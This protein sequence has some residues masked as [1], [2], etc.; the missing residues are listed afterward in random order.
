MYRPS[1]FTCTGEVKQINEPLM[2]QAQPKCLPAQGEAIEHELMTTKSPSELH[3]KALASQYPSMSF[4]K[5]IV[6]P[7]WAVFPVIFTL[8]CLKGLQYP[9]LVD[10][11][12][13]MCSSTSF[14]FT[15]SP[16]W[17]VTNLRST[18]HCVKHKC[19][20]MPISIGTPYGLEEH[21]EHLEKTVH[22][23]Q[24]HCSYS[25]DWQNSS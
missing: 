5:P 22:E 11:L 20:T 4:S 6:V 15:L 24:M 8:M 10:H 13:W 25:S 17:P 19:S 7:L 3:F 12:G 18:S 1:D 16:V 14:N 21:E 23:N 2:P 9:R